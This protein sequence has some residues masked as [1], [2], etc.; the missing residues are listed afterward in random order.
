M[1]EGLF[2][3]LSGRRSLD[4]KESLRPSAVDPSQDKKTSP[5]F[6]QKL[7]RP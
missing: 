7:T 2:F 6:H 4:E 5:I 3:T 1:P